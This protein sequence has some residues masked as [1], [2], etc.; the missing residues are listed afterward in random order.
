MPLL[1]GLPQWPDET[2]DRKTYAAMQQVHQALR[3]LDSAVE[4]ATGI[5]PYP[6]DEWNTIKPTGG[7]LI[8]NATRIYAPAMEAITAGQTINLSNNL[9]TLVAWR[10]FATSVGGAA[11]GIANNSASV[12]EIVEIQYM[13][14]LTNAIGGLT[15]GTIYYQSTT[16][17]V[18][19]PVRPTGTSQIVQAIGVAS[20][21]TQLMIAISLNFIIVP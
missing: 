12:G 21:S 20:S 4:Y 19:T 11:S 6:Q 3:N 1:T 14:G 10:A 5:E 18:I 7:F 9:G 17:G 8:Q 2:L 15:P 13:N 16:A